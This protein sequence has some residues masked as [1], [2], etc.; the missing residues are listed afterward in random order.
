[1]RWPLS[2]KSKVSKFVRRS[3]ISAYC[4]SGY[5]IRVKSNYAFVIRK[6]RERVD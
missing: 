5:P 2:E 6:V 1:M 4:I 3:G